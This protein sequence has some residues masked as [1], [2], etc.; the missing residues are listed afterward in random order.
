MDA[1]CCARSDAVISMAHVSDSIASMK[2][3]MTAAQCA[4]SNASLAREIGLLG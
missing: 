2:A 1:V 3:K 4:A